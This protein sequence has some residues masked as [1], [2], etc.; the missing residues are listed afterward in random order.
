MQDAHLKISRP[1]RYIVNFLLE[2]LEK[3]KI[4]MNVF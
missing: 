3:I 4:R 2:I 1:I